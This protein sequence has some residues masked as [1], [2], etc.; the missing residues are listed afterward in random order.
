M[1]NAGACNRRRYSDREREGNYP[2]RDEE[3]CGAMKRKETA[4]TATE[5]GT[6]GDEERDGNVRSHGNKVRAHARAK[7]KES[8]R[9]IELWREDYMHPPEM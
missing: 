5:R 7:G 8:S 2:T 4:D 1:W 9:E 6:A 3:N